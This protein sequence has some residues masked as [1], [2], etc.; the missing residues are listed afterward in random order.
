MHVVDNL[1]KK[2]INQILHSIIQ[3]TSIFDLHQIRNN[4]IYKCKAVLSQLPRGVD[5]VVL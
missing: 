4:I 2:K 5:Y 3:E 1:K